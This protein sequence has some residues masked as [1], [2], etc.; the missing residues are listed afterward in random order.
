MFYF[1]RPV[2]LLLDV[3]FRFWVVASCTVSFDALAPVCL[4]V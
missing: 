4:C 1:V 2:F 3:S